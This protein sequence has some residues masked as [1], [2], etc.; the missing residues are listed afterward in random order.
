M[1]IAIMQPY[2]LPYLGYF[3][4]INAVDK[5]VIYD[6]VQFVKNSWINRNRLLL[7]KKDEMISIPLKKGSNY[8]DIIDRDISNSFDKDKL[9]RKVKASYKGAPHFNEGIDLLEKCLYHE[10]ENLFNFLQHSIKV[11]NKYLC[12][13]TEVVVSSSLQLPR[14]LKSKDKVLSICKVLQCSDYINPEGG[15][16][17]YER[18]EFKDNGINLEFLKMKYFEYS[19]NSEQFISHLSILDVIMWNDKDKVKELIGNNYELF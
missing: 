13:D 18:G 5:F 17:L 7:N 15:V 2:F 1:K 19:Q 6:N 11:I 8:L 12:I 4:L 10:S 3:Q 9:L 14:E 16:D